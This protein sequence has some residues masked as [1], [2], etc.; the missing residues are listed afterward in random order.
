MFDSLQDVLFVLIVCDVFN[1][2]ALPIRVTEFDM[3][4]V[5]EPTVN[6]LIVFIDTILPYDY[7][8]LSFVQIESLH[9]I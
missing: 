7:S 4:P 3:S 6:A 2:V 9:P 1:R 5:Y 8:V